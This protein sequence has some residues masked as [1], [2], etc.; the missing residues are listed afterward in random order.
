[1]FLE[2]ENCDRA[3]IKNVKKCPAQ[4]RHVYSGDFSEFDIP[5]MEIYRRFSNF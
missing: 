1:M 2:E 4:Y 3:A 5:G